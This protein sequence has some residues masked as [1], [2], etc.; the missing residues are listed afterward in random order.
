VVGRPVT[1]PLRILTKLWKGNAF[2][3]FENGLKAAVKKLPQSLGDSAESL[4][5]IET[6]PRVGYRLLTQVTPTPA[7]R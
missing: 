7:N 4:Q 3:D 2:V 5:Y 1:S 6:L